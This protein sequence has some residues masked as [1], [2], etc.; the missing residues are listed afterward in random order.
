MDWF[1][2]RENLALYKKRLAETKDDATR[3]I[4]AKLLAEEMANEP[5]PKAR[6]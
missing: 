3:E 1:I 5:P 2:H 4:L 6:K